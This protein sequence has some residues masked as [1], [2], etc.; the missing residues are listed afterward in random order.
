MGEITVS[1]PVEARTRASAAFQNS[2]FIEAEVVPPPTLA[3]EIASLG[4]RAIRRVMLD[5]HEAVED[6]E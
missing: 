3:D 6:W 2:D 1:E 5:V 4:R